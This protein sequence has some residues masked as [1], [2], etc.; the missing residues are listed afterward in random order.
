VHSLTV[1]YGPNENEK[2]KTK[3]A[4]GVEVL[5]ANIET[6][7]GVVHIID[8]L[9]DRPRLMDFCPSLR[10]RLSSPEG[11]QQQQPVENVITNHSISL[12]KVSDQDLLAS[13]QY[14]PSN[15]IDHNAFDV[16]VVPFPKETDPSPEAKYGRKTIFFSHFSLSTAKT[17]VNTKSRI[18][19]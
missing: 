8:G 19:V 13:L 17:D 2:N 12:R 5:R 7:Y 6:D 18:G 10:Q 4:N 15:E 3:T 9:M 11:Q 14:D 16:V 1:H